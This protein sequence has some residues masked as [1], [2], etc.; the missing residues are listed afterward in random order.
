MLAPA[1][2]LKVAVAVPEVIVTD[3]GAVSAVLLLAS[4]TVEPEAGAG[5][6]NVT[7]QV[8]VSFGPRV[9]GLQAT[10]ETIDGATKLIVDV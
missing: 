3:A 7:V 6:A 8:A 2:A 4:V 9:P 1:V 5:W 10:P